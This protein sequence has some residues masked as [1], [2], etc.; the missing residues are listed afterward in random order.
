MF[1]L[2]PFINY[3]DAV[4]PINTH[5]VSNFYNSP[6]R[7]LYKLH[8]V[9]SENQ[10][11]EFLCLTPHSYLSVNEIQKVTVWFQNHIHQA[12]FRART[13]SSFP[14]GTVER[15]EEGMKVSSVPQTLNQKRGNFAQLKITHPRKKFAQKVL[16][17]ARRKLICEKAKHYLKEY[18]QMYG[19]EIRMARMARKA[20]TSMYLRNPDWHLSAG[21]A[22]SA[23]GAQ[24]SEVLQRLPLAG[25][26]AAPL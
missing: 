19:T 6:A 11:C 18:R 2:L 14:A 22:G 25:A 1:S 8:V 13:Q 15:A 20:A 12:A 9:D 26:S 5:S 10:R 16:G 4:G 17:K 3:Y 24:R 23:V 21:S 7:F